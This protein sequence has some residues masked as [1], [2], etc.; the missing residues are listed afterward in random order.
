MTL[1]KS[2]H[3]SEPHCVVYKARVSA[4]AFKGLFICSR[5]N[6]NISSLPTVCQAPMRHQGPSGRTTWL[7]PPEHPHRGDG[8]QTGD[9]TMQYQVRG[10]LG[11]EWCGQG[12]LSRQG[13]PEDFSGI[14][15]GE[16]ISGR[17]NIRDIRSGAA[18]LLCLTV[19]GGPGLSSF[20]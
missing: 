7:C 3:L 2:P 19:R 12:S 1:D 11:R 17:G 10:M 5:F 6:T 15:A 4:A 9:C 20:V 8:Q 13:L 18:G 14:N 16:R